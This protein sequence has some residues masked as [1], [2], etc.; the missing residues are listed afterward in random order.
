MMRVEQKLVVSLPA[1]KEGRH[2]MLLFVCI[3]GVN[4]PARIYFKVSILDFKDFGR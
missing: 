1:S 3:T 2:P 4:E